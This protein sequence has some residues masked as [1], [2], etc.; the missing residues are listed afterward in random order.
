MSLPMEEIDEKALRDF[1]DEDLLMTEV[2]CGEPELL[3]LD[4]YLTEILRS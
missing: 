1:N 3:Y 2:I 4:S